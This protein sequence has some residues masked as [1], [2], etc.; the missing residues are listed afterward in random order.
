MG[1]YGRGGETVDE[2]EGDLDEPDSIVL[3]DGDLVSLPAG[4]AGELVLVQAGVL[5]ASTMAR[6]G[7]ERSRGRGAKGCARRGCGVRRCCHAGRCP[8]LLQRCRAERP[9]PDG[10]GRRRTGWRWRGTG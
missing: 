8:L 6:G 5:C 1:F 9:E 2:D 7:R 4:D 10:A 3:I